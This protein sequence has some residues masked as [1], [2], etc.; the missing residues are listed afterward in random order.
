MSSSADVYPTAADIAAMSTWIEKVPFDTLPS[1]CYV[2]DEPALRRNLKLL[3][4]V[5]QEAGCN[6][7]LALKSFALF[8]AFPVIQQTLRGTTASGLDET[9]LGHRE[10]RGEVHV[11]A[12][13]Y[14]EDDFD[15]IVHCADHIV[16]NSIAQWTRFGSR[17]LAGGVQCGLRLNPEHSEVTPPVY[18]PCRPGSRLGIT[19]AKFP[20]I[21]PDGI[22]GLH[23]HTLCERGADALERT[24]AVVE[25]KF[26]RHL[27]KV[28]WVNFGGGHHITRMDYDI[29][30]LIRLIRAFRERYGVSVYL[31]PGEAIAL[32]SGVLVTSV[33]DILENRDRIAILDT[34][35][36]AHMPDVLEMPYRPVIAGAGNPGE[37]GYD[38]RLAGMTCLA[39]DE[40]GVYSFARPLRSGDRIIFLDMA[41]Y[42]MVKNT[43]FNG[44]RLPSIAI[45]D[46]ARGSARVVR[47]FD[48]SD[49]RGR[50]G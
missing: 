43:T 33:L 8:H 20:P 24:L 4:T 28:Q 38:Y 13:A 49:F 42:T 34:S 25:A 9:L 31:E 12:P 19:A 46:S 35:A 37:R 39:G 3:D 10:F 50:L 2:V 11:C 5:Q 29:G 41:H 30:R 32:Y 21:L 23:F 14:R 45:S 40:I 26:A 1:P 48:Y 47:T 44:V 16:F 6:I 15:D 22:T 7:L 27:R 36:S 17:A 18:D